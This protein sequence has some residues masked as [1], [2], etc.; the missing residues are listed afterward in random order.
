M[1][2]FRQKPVNRLTQ[3]A[4]QPQ[5]QPP[6]TSTPVNF[7]PQQLP[8]AEPIALQPLTDEPGVVNPKPKKSR[9]KVIIW[10]IVGFFSALILVFGGILVWYNVQLSPVD[11]S[12]TDKKLVKI[13]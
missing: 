6:A 8:L 11:S 13:A 1:D 4:P 5:P 12:N 7:A 3:P 9:K 10:S 2:D